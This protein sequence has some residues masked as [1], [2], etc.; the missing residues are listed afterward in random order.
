MIILGSREREKLIGTMSTFGGRRTFMRASPSAG[1]G[2]NAIS[3]ILV[4]RLCIF[5]SR[6][7][8]LSMHSNIKISEHL[9]TV[10]IG[11]LWYSAPHNTPQKDIALH[12]HPGLT[13][14]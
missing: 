1:A 3:H 5:Y 9:W 4:M 7:A 11:Q 13:R 6:N 14:A 8:D 10:L 12:D 2:S